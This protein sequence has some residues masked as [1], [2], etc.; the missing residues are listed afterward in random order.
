MTGTAVNRIHLWSGPR[1]ISTAMMYSF[2]QRS[3]TQV[4][5]EPLYAHYLR[6]TGLQHPGREEVLASQENDGQRVVEWMM[7]ASFTKPVVFFKQMTHH[8]INLPF[9]FLAS[10]KNILLIRDPKDVLISY[11]KV[12]EHP[13]LTDIG[14]RQSYE[15]FQFLQSRQY[16]AIVLDADEVLHNAEAMMKV[17]CGAL[18][19]AFQPAMLR[20]QPGAR[21]EDGVWAK[22]WYSKVHQ[23]T[24]LTRFE[25]TETELPLGLKAV[26]A[27]AM[28]YYRFLYDHSIKP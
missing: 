28:P 20:W 17:L 1:N 3:D 13:A 11:S 6:E 14:I 4:V 24:G 9:D 10:C 23:S 21:P 19:I 12:I 8:L 2:A 22:Y 26:R 16:H 5:D 27:E 15:L 18:G 7:S 25:K